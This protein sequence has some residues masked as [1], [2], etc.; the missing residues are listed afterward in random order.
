MNQGARDANNESDRE[1]KAKFHHDT[2][3]L[4]RQQIAMLKEIKHLLERLVNASDTNG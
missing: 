4:Q 1:A 3:A 2:L